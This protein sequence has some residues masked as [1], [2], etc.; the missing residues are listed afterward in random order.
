VRAQQLSSNTTSPPVPGPAIAA[1]PGPTLPVA[2][3]ERPCP[4]CGA[5]LGEQCYLMTSGWPPRVWR[6]PYSHIARL[7]PPRPLVRSL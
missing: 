6:T 4:T 5:E 7:E 3:S 1:G 2:F